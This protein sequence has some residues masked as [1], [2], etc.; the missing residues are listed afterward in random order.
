MDNKSILSY[1]KDHYRK[2]D[3]AE[4]LMENKI[5]NDIL[6]EEKEKEKVGT[7]I[8]PNIK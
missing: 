6:S 5:N 2:E 4:L 7:V 3:E 8:K 1:L